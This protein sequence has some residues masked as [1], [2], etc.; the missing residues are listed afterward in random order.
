MAITDKALLVGNIVERVQ[1]DLFKLL[2]AP[3]TCVR[4]ALPKRF[5]IS[6]PKVARFGNWL[7]QQ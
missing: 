4:V 7:F 6:N 1:V 2:V 5:Q 3:V